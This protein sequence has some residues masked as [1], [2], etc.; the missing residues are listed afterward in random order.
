M[1]SFLL[2]HDQPRFYRVA[3]DETLFGDYAVLREWGKRGSGGSRRLALFGNLR[4]AVIAADRW[5][6]R[7]LRRGYHMS[8]RQ[9]G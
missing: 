9:I 8:E 2:L 1:L 6:S 5:Q 4:E 3:V 7:A